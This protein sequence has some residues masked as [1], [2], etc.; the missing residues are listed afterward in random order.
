LNF[1]TALA[2]LRLIGFIEGTSA[3]LLFCVAMPWK[4]LIDEPTGKHVVYAVGMT[5]GILWTLYIA[6]VLNAAIVRKW[7][8]GRVVV[9]G[10]ASIPPFATFI[11]DRSLRREQ[12]DEIPKRDPV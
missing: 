12:R 4:Y 10:L 3:V 7:G 8:I 2:R 6:A 9:A 5:H 1:R 11:F